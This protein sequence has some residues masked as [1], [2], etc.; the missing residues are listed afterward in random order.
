MP[1]PARPDI[2]QSGVRLHLAFGF[3]PVGLRFE[4]EI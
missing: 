2:N 3:A 4:R 1:V